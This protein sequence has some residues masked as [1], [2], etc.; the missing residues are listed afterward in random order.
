[1]ISFTTPDYDV[2]RK[3]SFMLSYYS[4]IILMSLIA[5]GVLSLLIRDNNRLSSEDK[6]LLYETCSLIAV[7][8]I[9]E[10]GRCSDGRPKRY[11]G[12][13]SALCQMP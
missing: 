7:S 10:W 1:M 4:A 3:E 12:L 6:R 11:P 13:D 9:A 2:Y 5:L 8:A